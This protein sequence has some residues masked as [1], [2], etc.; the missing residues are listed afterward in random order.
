MTLF[1]GCAE[2]AFGGVLLGKVFLEIL[3]NLQENA[4]ARVSFLI[5][6]QA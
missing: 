6:F 3:Q 5:K 1:F 4:C 2:P